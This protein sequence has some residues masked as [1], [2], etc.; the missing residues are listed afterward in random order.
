MECCTSNVKLSGLRPNR[1]QEVSKG[2]QIDSWR[3]DN[4]RPVVGW[5]DR[6]AQQVIT[7]KWGVLVQRPTRDHLP[8]RIDRPA[9]AAGD[10]DSLRRKL[11]NNYGIAIYEKMSGELNDKKGGEEKDNDSNSE[12]GLGIQEVV[13]GKGTRKCKKKGPLDRLAKE[14]PA[15][16][17]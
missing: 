16:P 1:V 11:A 5:P 7:L 10:S 9:K 15:H 12:N 6:N 2:S 17:G 3:N 8:G 4:G 13:D 14:R